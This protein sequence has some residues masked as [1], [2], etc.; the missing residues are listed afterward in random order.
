MTSEHAD[1]TRGAAVQAGR[2][3]AGS[4]QRIFIPN[5]AATSGRVRSVSSVALWLPLPD[6]R[7]DLIGSI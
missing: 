4:N 1:W 7:R 3:A 2:F 6:T 5:A